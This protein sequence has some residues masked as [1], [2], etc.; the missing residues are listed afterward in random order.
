MEL[1][2]KWRL[3]KDDTCVTLQFFEERERTKKNGSKEVYEY[4]DSYYYPNLKEA[5]KG[6]S[7][8]YVMP[9]EYQDILIRLERLE[10]LISS[11]AL[12]DLVLN[13]K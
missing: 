2:E 1:T 4:T 3:L 9:T 10:T 5:L 7:R 11:I 13:K 12:E 6:F 8:K